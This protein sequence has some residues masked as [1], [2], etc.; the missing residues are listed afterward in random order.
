MLFYIVLFIVIFLFTLSC[1]FSIVDKIY[2]IN[3]VF[4]VKKKVIKLYT[5]SSMISLLC[6]LSYCWIVYKVF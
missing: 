5:I 6:S 4:M 2:N 1:V 3:E